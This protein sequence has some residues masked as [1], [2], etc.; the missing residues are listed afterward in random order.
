MCF[1]AQVDKLKQLLKTVT[2]VLSERNT[3]T[4]YRKRLY[5]CYA[6]LQ[7]ELEDEKHEDADIAEVLENSYGNFVIDNPVSLHAFIQ[8]NH[9]VAHFVNAFFCLASN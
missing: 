6:T 5:N 1:K 4:G 3:F 8:H 2:Q 7:D 9:A